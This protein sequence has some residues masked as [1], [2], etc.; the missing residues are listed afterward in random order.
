MVRNAAEECQKEYMKAPQENM[1]GVVCCVHTEGSVETQ[2]LN[3][4]KILRTLAGFL[5][6]PNVGASVIVY[7]NSF[8]CLLSVMRSDVVNRDSILQAVQAIGYDPQSLPVKWISLE[9]T[10]A[11]P[12]LLPATIRSVIPQA[13][14]AQRSAQPVASLCLALQCG[15]SD[16]FSGITANPL[17]GS[18]AEKVIH[19]GGS[20]I[21]AETDELIGADAYILDKVKDV[22]TARQFMATQARYE[23]TANVMGVSAQANPSGGNFYRGLYNIAIKSLGAA[24]KKTANTRLEGVLEYSERI[25]ANGAGYYF[26]DTPGNDIE[27]V[28]GQVAGG[29]TVILFSTGNGSIT[30]F[31]FVPISFGPADVILLNGAHG[32]VAYHIAAVRAAGERSGHQCREVPGWDVDGAAL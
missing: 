6:H 19:R 31:P 16:A 27:S 8:S 13:L 28:T 10:V 9:D 22:A 30:N 1:D 25:G 29:C 12:S 24:M 23:H 11:D 14:A 2:P 5:I 18:I 3:K 7:N 26:M 15:G 17:Q 32:E 21:L 20:A 4:D